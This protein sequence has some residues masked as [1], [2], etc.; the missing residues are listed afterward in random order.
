MENFKEYKRGNKYKIL[1]LSIILIFF[2]GALVFIKNDYFLYKEIIVKAVDVSESETSGV[3]AEP[4]YTQ[5]VEAKIMNGENKGRMIE[6]ENE[7]SYSGLFDYN[8][9]KGDD[10][11]V[12]LRDDLSVT[13]VSGFKRDFWP[14]LEISVFCFALILVAA[15]KAT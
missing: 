9:R 14:A 10:I 7:R 2:I 5:K 13:S 3:T 1:T 4:D 11:F 6:F 15:K 12:M 8:I